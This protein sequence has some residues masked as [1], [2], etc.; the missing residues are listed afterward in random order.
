ML[1]NRLDWPSCLGGSLKSQHGI[2]IFLIFLWSSHQVSMKMVFK[3]SSDFILLFQDLRFPLCSAVGPLIELILRTRK[4]SV[5]QSELWVIIQ[6]HQKRCTLE[7]LEIRSVQWKFLKW[8]EK[9]APAKSIFKEA[10]YK[11]ALLYLVAH[12]YQQW[13][14]IYKIHIKTFGVGISYFSRLA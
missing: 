10:V 1:H 7:F 11:E 6:R 12:L 3:T 2:L 13:T 9:H 4:I 8:I 5:F 14:F